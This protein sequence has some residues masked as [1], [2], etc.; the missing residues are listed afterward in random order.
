VTY[1]TIHVMEAKLPKPVHE[2]YRKHR[3]DLAWK[4]LF[5]VIFSSVLCVGLVVLINFATFRDGGDVARWAG[6]STIWIA[7]P[8]IVGLLIVL[9]VL[10]GIIYGLARLLD[11]TPN[12]TAMAQDFFHKVE[13]YAKRGADAVADQ[14]IRINAIG[15]S[16]GRIFKRQ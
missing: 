7:I 9:A 1:A 8:T 10:G 6:I 11:V 4:I 5:P 16:I 14:V 3:K 2:S 15:A 13:G 12:Y